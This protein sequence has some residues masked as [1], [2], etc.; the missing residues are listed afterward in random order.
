MLS[1]ALGLLMQAAPADAARRVTTPLPQHEFSAVRAAIA[2]AMAKDSIPALA[3]A[4]VRDGRIVWEEA[5]GTSDAAG[6]VATTVHTPF[7]LASVTKTLTATAIMTLA[8]RGK[9]DIDR[10]ANL[11]LPTGS[12]LSSHGP[13]TASSATVRHILTHTSGL[14]TFSWTCYDD[15]RGCH[16]PTADTVITRYGVLMFP[17][18]EHFDY[19]NLGFGV[20]GEIVA[21]VTGMSFGSALRQIVFEPLQMQ[22]ASLDV[23]RSRVAST[24]VRVSRARGT[25]MFS[26]SGGAGASIGFASA[27]DLAQLALFNLGRLPNASHAISPATVRTMHNATVPSDNAS[28]VYG[29]GWWIYPDRNGFRVL[30]AQ[31]GT[32][33]AYASVLIVPEA[34]LA[35]VLLANTGTT[36]INAVIDSVFD[37]TLPGYRERRVRGTVATERSA[38]AKAGAQV[39][40][41]LAGTWTGTVRTPRGPIPLTLQV[42]ANG[43]V[44]GR[45]GSGRDTLL[46]RVTFGALTNGVSMVSGRLP[47]ELGMTGDIGPGP[48]DVYVELYHRDGKLLGLA[49][50]YPKAEAPYGAR[51]TFAV[52]LERG[53]V[54]RTN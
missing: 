43:S 30:S 15:Q 53:A 27:H 22:D 18:G 29:L 37:V 26:T 52:A 9:L 4:V 51:L 40:V 8:E 10:P 35:V 3:I 19:T 50:S 13:W 32:D 11:Y 25:H 16:V 14:S 39:P 44:R 34:D 17:P 21:N 38:P 5:F 28:S 31:G 12:Q 33:D 46:S 48:V 7:Y 45:I 2:S 47:G 49:T 42:D 54:A 24:A 41:Q 36:A 20:L 23:D 6:S 1:L